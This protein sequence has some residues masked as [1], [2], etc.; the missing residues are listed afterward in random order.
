MSY[1]NRKTEA[2]NEKS[3]VIT[4]LAKILFRLAQDPESSET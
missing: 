4:L 3:E 2:R 1:D